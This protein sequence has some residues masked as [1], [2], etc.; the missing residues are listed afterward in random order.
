MPYC[1][2]CNTTWVETGCGQD[3]EHGS[4]PTPCSLCGQLMHGREGIGCQGHPI[5]AARGYM[6][7]RFPDRD[8]T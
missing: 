4:C 5:D 2:G 1:E 6:A 7:R 3:D 8:Q